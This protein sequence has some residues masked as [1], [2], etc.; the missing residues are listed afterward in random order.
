MLSTHKMAESPAAEQSPRGVNFSKSRTWGPLDSNPVHRNE[1]ETV[2]APPSLH[3]ERADDIVDKVIARPPAA[4]TTTYSAALSKA[5][6][7]APPLAELTPPPSPSRDS[8][9][10]PSTSS[11]SPATSRT[12]SMISNPFASTG[13]SPLLSKMTLAQGQDAHPAGTAGQTP[14]TH[15]KSKSSKTTLPVLTDL[16]QGSSAP[17]TF[18]L[19]PSPKK[20]QP[21]GPSPFG[22]NGRSSVASSPTRPAHVRRGSTL[23]AAAS[24]LGL[25]SN[26]PGSVSSSRQ[27]RALDIESLDEE[28]HN[29]DDIQNLDLEAEL[30]PEGRPS[31]HE[32]KAAGY[33]SL[34]GNS[35]RLSMRLREAYSAKVWEVR[36]MHEMQ[37]AEMEEMEQAKT[38]ERHLKMQLSEMAG[39]VAKREDDVKALISE[40]EREK[41][42]RAGTES[43][44]RKERS[45]RV[46]D[47]NAGESSVK[48][49]SGPLKPKMPE[50]EKI[51][52]ADS[53][54]RELRMREGDDICD[55]SDEGHS[56]GGSIFDRSTPPSE[57]SCPSTAPDS[58][59]VANHVSEQ[60]VSQRK[61]MIWEE[62]APYLPPESL[63]RD[64]NQQLR[65][66]IA[67]L[68]ETV[69][70]CLGLVDG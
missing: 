59:A 28:S 48:E 27:S 8:L 49:H 50:R 64:E 26:R 57:A 3:D 55:S 6:Q 62:A 24:F 25:S 41:E 20:E 15:H 9:P 10:M 65:K 44:L 61:S 42:K 4:F 5:I 7:E 31:G 14:S 66:R 39:C 32:A 11:S 1:D 35:E 2:Q 30:L 56:D 16:L 29:G 60:R 58:E 68:E 34:L 51:F 43:A 37:K 19:V 54:E 18:G 53:A 70:M 22:P 13:S 21:S 63:L 23:Q 67:E 12:G 33:D 69:Q 45:I 46:V 52:S 40:I 47:S 36:A 17:V 38:R